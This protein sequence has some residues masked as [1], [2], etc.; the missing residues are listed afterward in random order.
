VYGCD[1]TSVATVD[2]SGT[3]TGIAAGSANTYTITTS[4]GLIM[5]DSTVNPL[6]Q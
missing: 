6:P 2:A 5:G 4:C 1:N 3:V